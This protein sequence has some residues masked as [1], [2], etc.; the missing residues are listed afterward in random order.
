MSAFD[1]AMFGKT[2]IGNFDK[3]LK[4]SSDYFAG[5]TTFLVENQLLC[6]SEYQ[7]LE[8]IYHIYS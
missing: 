1:V 6:K 3:I 5:H 2:S 4:E 7:A 8:L